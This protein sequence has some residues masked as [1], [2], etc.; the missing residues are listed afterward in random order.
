MIFLWIKIDPWAG[1]LAYFCLVML[2]MLAYQIGHGKDSFLGKLLRGILV[3]NLA[4]SAHWGCS[5]GIDP[6]LV[7]YSLLQP[8][9]GEFLHATS[10]TSFLVPGMALRKPRGFDIVCELIL[11]VLPF[12]D[13]FIVLYAMLD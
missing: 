7:G 13:R 2:V 5:R 9:E 3:L 1:I 4:G 11:N 10:S 6:Y 12:L 8:Q